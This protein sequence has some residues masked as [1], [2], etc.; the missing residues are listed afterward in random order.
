MKAVAASEGVSVPVI[1]R[2]SGRWSWVRRVTEYD[3]HLA[4]ELETRRLRDIDKMSER[5]TEAALQFQE[6]MMSMLNN[7]SGRIRD[8]QLDSLTT[9]EILD[10]MLKAIRD[11]P[12]IAKME[13]LS[14]G[15]PESIAKI[16][17][18]PRIR[19]RAIQ[20]GIDPEEAVKK[21]RK[22]LGA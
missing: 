13:R 10:F 6:M 4:V 11:W 7:I 14:R 19:E 16:D 8:G 18:E 2:L 3:K 22:L 5:H 21:A 1:K 15:E 17:I 9:D 20:M 12:N